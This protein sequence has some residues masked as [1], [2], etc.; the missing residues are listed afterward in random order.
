VRGILRARYAPNLESL[1]LRHCRLDRNAWA[2]LL[3]PD[4]L[5]NL[6]RLFLAGTSINGVSICVPGKDATRLVG[7]ARE[8]FGPDAVDIEQE[9]PVRPWYYS[10]WQK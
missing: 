9:F 10:W 1:E 3:S 5:P 2:D 8:R 4:V 6:K 7:R